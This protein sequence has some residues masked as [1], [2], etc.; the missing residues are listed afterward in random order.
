MLDGLQLLEHNKCRES[1]ARL[2]I[3]LLESLILLC[4]SRQ[5][6]D[7]FRDIKVYALLQ[8]MHLAE[9]DETVIN[10]IEKVVDLLIRDEEP[11]VGKIEEIVEK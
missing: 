8:K 3:L 11:F 1:D 7:K 6:R 5:G 2:R 9:K 4:T 10:E